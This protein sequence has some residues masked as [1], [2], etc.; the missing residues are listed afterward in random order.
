M[1]I[2]T[3]SICI[4]YIK[5]DIAI[6]CEYLQNLQILV[7]LNYFNRMRDWPKLKDESEVLLND[8]VITPL[9]C[10]EIKTEISPFFD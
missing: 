10:I 2:E 9:K 3:S 8:L 4:N 1:A 5:L 6:D 7:T